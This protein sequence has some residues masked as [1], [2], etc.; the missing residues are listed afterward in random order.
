MIGKLSE[1]G[2]PRATHAA[3][4]PAYIYTVGRNTKNR[5]QK[6]ANRNQ[7]NS[8]KLLL[9]LILPNNRKYLKTRQKTEKPKT[10]EGRRARGTRDEPEEI[11]RAQATH[12]GLASPLVF[13]VV[14][15][16]FLVV[17]VAI[18]AHQLICR[19]TTREEEHQKEDRTPRTAVRK[20]TYLP[21]VVKNYTSE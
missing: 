15:N 5:K 8:K 1:Q 14:D 3:T 18:N 21:V 20:H 6:M 10:D 11:V 2:K 12:V 4:I 13:E 16:A 9:I 19:G 7:Q 17:E